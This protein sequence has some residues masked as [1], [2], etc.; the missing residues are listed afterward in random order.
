MRK[1]F[2]T[3]LA[4]AAA[5]ALLALGAAAP[6]TAAAPLTSDTLTVGSAG[7]T[8][9]A[10]GNTLSA[11]LTG[12]STLT[13]SAG[14]ISCT[15]GS[16]GATV[17]ANGAATATETVTSFA[18]T[19]T[20]CTSKIT[21]TTSV[22]SI[23]LKSGTAP[24]AT[25]TGSTSQLTVTPVVTVVL[26]TILGDVTCYYSGAATGTL[27]NTAHSLAFSG[28]A[29]TKQTGSSSLC[30]SSGTFTATYEPVVDTSLSSQ[31]V[32]VN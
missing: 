18:F 14:N 10:V 3:G 19:N 32:Y 1:N 7:G 27:S 24:V 25:V 20:S 13:T 23:G 12:T 31:D 4:A 9:V 15:Q 30:P 21:G 2:Y 28:V 16:F 8:A 5:T 29:V 11:A 17:T 26:G 22:Q 6:A